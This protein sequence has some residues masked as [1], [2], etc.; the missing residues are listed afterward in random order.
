M[1]IKFFTNLGGGGKG[2]GRV[3]VEFIFLTYSFI[4]FHECNNKNIIIIS[5]VFVVVYV[6]YF[7]NTVVHIDVFL[8]FFPS[9]GKLT[10]G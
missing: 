4:L 9:P 5:A 10:F 2:A 3:R 8:M 7:T 6:I 1:D